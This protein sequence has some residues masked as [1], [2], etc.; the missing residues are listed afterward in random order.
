MDDRVARC[1]LIAQVLSADGMMTDTERDFLK[2]AMTRMGLSDEERE[3]VTY[4][5]NT[6]GAEEAIAELPQ[7]DRREFLDELVV[8]ALVDGKLSPQ[9]LASVKRIALALGFDD[10]YGT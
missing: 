2:K 6:D 5:E 7:Q 10:D 1:H 4:F 3:Q 8:A 9:E